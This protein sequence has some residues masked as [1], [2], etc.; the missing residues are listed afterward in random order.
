MRFTFVPCSL[1]RLAW[2]SR[3]QRGSDV[4]RVCHGPWVEARASLF[5]SNSL[6]FVLA[7]ADDELDPHYPFF[8]GVPARDDRYVEHAQT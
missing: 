7:M 2:P 5:A 6:V 4:A 1:P 8:P 3:V